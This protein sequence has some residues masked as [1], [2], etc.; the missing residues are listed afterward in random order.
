MNAQTGE[1]KKQ[2]TEA[3]ANKGRTQTRMLISCPGC[4]KPIPIP[5]TKGT[6]CPTCGS[7]IDYVNRMGH[8]EKGAGIEFPESEVW[9]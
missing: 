6:K 5:I 7:S 1:D 2:E 4:D 3:Q 9:H 8:P